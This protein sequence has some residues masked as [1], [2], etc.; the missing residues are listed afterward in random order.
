MLAALACIRSGLLVS[1]AVSRD[2]G[3]N[4]IT[5]LRSGLAYIRRVP[6]LLMVTAMLAVF[7]VF[8]WNFN[9]IVPL[10]T[11]RALNAGPDVFGVLLAGI[12][13]GALAAALAWA[14]RNAYERRPLLI[15]AGMF[16]CAYIAAGLSTTV[17]LGF[18]ALLVVGYAHTIYNSASI[19]ALQLLPPE[20]LRGR[21]VSLYTLLFLGLQP[22]GSLVT[23]Y[24]ADS[25]SIRW[26]IVLE[27]GICLSTVALAA[28][29]TRH[30]TGE[31]RAA[32]A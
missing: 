6:D 17:A 10:L 14:R 13:L 1:T 15:A 32:P 28:W 27:G 5:Q 7:G 11:Q 18:L 25:F 23:G 24:L 21:T 20:H 8:S 22:V 9:V 16:S 2:S 12:G 29:F 4:L 26:V 30:T 31:T 19:T 3:E